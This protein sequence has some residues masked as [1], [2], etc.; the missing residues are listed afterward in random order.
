M[1]TNFS[2]FFCKLQT[3]GSANRALWR[4][5]QTPLEGSCACARGRKR[6]LA[7]KSQPLHKSTTALQVAHF[8]INNQRL[9]MSLSKKDVEYG[10]FS[11]QCGSYVK[12]MMGGTVLQSSNSGGC[13]THLV[14]STNLIRSI[15]MAVKNASKTNMRFHAQALLK[16]EWTQTLCS[17]LTGNTDTSNF[18]DLKGWPGHLAAF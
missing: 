9:G 12:Q 6:L 4:L 5:T 13:E 8:I 1:V 16:R 3:C 15:S 18:L 14:L 17:T 10:H 2:L 7:L 11:P